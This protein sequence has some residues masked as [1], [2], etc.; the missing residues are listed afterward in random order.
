VKDRVKG[1][2]TVPL[3]TGDADFATCFRHFHRLGFDRWF[4]LQA[5]RE[6]GLSETELAAVNRRKVEAWVARA[7]QEAA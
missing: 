4:I 3:T 5:A 1:G 6:E 2:F 7:A